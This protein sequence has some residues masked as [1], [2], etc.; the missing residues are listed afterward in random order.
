MHFNNL[1]QY[2]EASNTAFASYQRGDLSAFSTIILQCLPYDQS[3]DDE[4]IISWL[5]D[6][7]KPQNE[8]LGMQLVA[9]EDKESL[10]LKAVCVQHG[11]GFDENAELAMI[12]AEQSAALGYEPAQHMVAEHYCS[13]RQKDLKKAYQIVENSSY[14]PSLY[15]R[16][17]LLKGIYIPEERT[18]ERVILEEMTEG[19]VKKLAR[20]LLKKAAGNQETPGYAP[21]LVALA[22]ENEP[23]SLLLSSKAAVIGNKEAIVQLIDRLNET[24]Y[25]QLEH[26]GKMLFQTC[27][28]LADDEDPSAMTLL[29]TLYM[30]GIGTEQ[31]ITE[32]VGWYR[33]SVDEY[34]DPAAQYLLAMYYRDNRYGQRDLKQ[35][36]SLMVDA[37]G[38]NYS[39]A[40]KEI[41]AVE[42]EYEASCQGPESSR[43][44]YLNE[45]RKFQFHN[46]SL[47]GFSSMSDTTGLHTSRFM[48]ASPRDSANFR[49]L[50]QQ[51][52]DAL[53][54]A[55][56]VISYSNERI[57]DQFNRIFSV[58]NIHLAYPYKAVSDPISN[59][60]RI[61]MHI[62]QILECEAANEII[63][64]QQPKLILRPWVEE[65]LR[66]ET[67]VKKR[68]RANMDGDNDTMPL[69]GNKLREFVRRIESEKK[70]VSFSLG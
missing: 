63:A 51:T 12:I 66:T 60:D 10:Y 6:D 18:K 25:S 46:V 62:H 5:K 35:A 68:P 64:A 11:I 55:K 29:G 67:V 19:G 43:K 9:A 61:G 27:A 4:T 33:N 45:S 8:R 47:I 39:L 24:N 26:I 16:S 52:F 28:A 53:E 36:H 54:E 40:K 57:V 48:L 59:N 30:H 42:A 17:R 21:A 3:I 22:E 14:P 31:N 70:T 44:Q 7:C 38:Q 32:A 1:T 50:N 49:N 65:F 56:V 20:E 37:W 34:S 41:D 58:E 69:G 15:L 13:G 23:R 2:R